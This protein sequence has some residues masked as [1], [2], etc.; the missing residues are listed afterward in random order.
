M[1]QCGIPNR[2]LNIRRN[3]VPFLILFRGFGLQ[4]YAN[5]IPQ[6]VYFMRNFKDDID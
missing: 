1:F 5:E 2:N 3:L 4:R 6:E